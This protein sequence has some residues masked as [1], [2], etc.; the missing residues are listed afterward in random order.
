MV[1]DTK[2]DSALATGIHDIVTRLTAGSISN[3]KAEA[4]L[5]ALFAVRR[6]AENG[7]E[8]LRTHD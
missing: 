3:D 6:A 8:A 4:E 1:S 7:I 2:N 5:L